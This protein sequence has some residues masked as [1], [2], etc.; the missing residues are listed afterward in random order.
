MNRP[1]TVTLTLKE[2]E[3]V[4]KMIAIAEA[5]GRSEGDYQAWTR[6]NWKALEALSEKML[7]EL[8]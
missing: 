7:D 3:T 5:L 2:R 8:E 1:K 6:A 4:L